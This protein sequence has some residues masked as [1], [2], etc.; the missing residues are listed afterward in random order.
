MILC[1]CGAVKLIPGEKQKN[2][3]KAHGIGIISYKIVNEKM[4]CIGQYHPKNPKIGTPLNESLIKLF[5]SMM[6]P[7]IPYLFCTDA[8]PLG[9]V[10]HAEYLASQGRKVLMSFVVKHDSSGKKHLL[11]KF[12]DTN[13]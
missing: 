6:M 9:S 12:L 3:R 1:V 2:D 8:R 4:F 13:L 5:E 10:P 7:N 11:I